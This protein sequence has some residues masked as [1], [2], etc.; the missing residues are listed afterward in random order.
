MLTSALGVHLIA[1]VALLQPRAR[2]LVF[3]CSD[4]S[5]SGKLSRGEWFRTRKNSNRSRGLQ[6]MASAVWERNWKLS[7]MTKNFSPLSQ[8]ARARN[9][10]LTHILRPDILIDFKDGVRCSQ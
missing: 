8:S 9:P 5:C 6:D 10:N 3:S 2:Q 7:G 4:S 1:L